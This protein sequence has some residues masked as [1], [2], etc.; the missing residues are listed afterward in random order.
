MDDAAV[1]GSDTMPLPPA[2]APAGA[3]SSHGAHPAVHS[4]IPLA[5]VKHIPDPEKR[6]DAYRSLIRAR[7]QSSNLRWRSSMTDTDSFVDWLADDEYKLRFMLSDEEE[8]YL[9]ADQ[10]Y[11]DDAAPPFQPLIFHHSSSPS[12]T[13]PGFFTSAT[14]P[15]VRTRIVQGATV[16]VAPN[17][18]AE[19]MQVD[20]DDG[21]AEVTPARATLPLQQPDDTK[22][23][24]R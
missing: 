10:W 12:S 13:K 14:G 3:A 7:L 22:K 5:D 19:A 4:L 18:E 9:V 23:R 1:L 2:Q 11:Y 8:L 24:R 6:L 16:P 15:G 17:S 20:G 21:D